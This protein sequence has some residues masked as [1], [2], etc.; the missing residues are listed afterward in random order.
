MTPL[1]L[2]PVAELMPRKDP[3]ARAALL[4]DIRQHGVRVPIVVLQDQ[5]LDGRHRYGACQT[6]K[7]PCPPSR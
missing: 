2:H 3:T 6:L 7:I 4:E 1:P 5:I